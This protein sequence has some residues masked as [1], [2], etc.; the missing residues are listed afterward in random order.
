MIL[1]GPPECGVIKELW[2]DLNQKYSSLADSDK[3]SFLMQLTVST[4]AYEEQLATE[5]DEEIFELCEDKSN[6]TPEEFRK[7]ILANVITT[8]RWLND[9]KHILEEIDY[10]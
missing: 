6:I 1:M 8:K 3:I 7:S 5:S 9:N 4:M 10:G 2:N